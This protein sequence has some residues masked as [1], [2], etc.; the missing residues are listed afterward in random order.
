[1]AT[2]PF[3]V[4][5]GTVSLKVGRAGEKIPSFVAPPLFGKPTLRNHE[6]EACDFS[7]G[8]DSNW[9]DYAIFPLNPKEKHDNTLPVA[10]VTYENGKY[11]IS[12]DVM[13]KL[14]EFATSSK[15]VDDIMEGGTVIATEPTVHTP[16]F[17]HTMAE[18]LVESQ[19][20][21]KFYLC[22]RASLCC[23]ASGRGSSMVVDV[24]GACSNVA[25]VSEGFVLQEA[26]NE[27]PMGGTLLDRIFLAYLNQNSTTIRPS[28]E[29]VKAPKAEEN[30]G[31]KSQKTNNEMRSV[32]LRKLPYVRKEYYEYAR[33]YATSR[34]KETCCVIGEKLNV[35]A[36]PSNSCF[37]LPDGS[38][39]DVD[40]G[41]D[42]CG[43]FCRCLFN[44][45]EY[46]Q[47]AKK[48]KALESQEFPMGVGDGGT[49]LGQYFGRYC[50]LDG[51]L[52]KSYETASQMDSTACIP[53]ALSTVILSGGT[54]RHSAVL[55][56]LQKRFNDRMPG[57][58]EPSYMAVGGE[59]QQY[60]S[61]IGASILS[62][63]GIFESLC[64]SR[65][66]CQEHGLERILQRK[67]P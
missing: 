2:K 27:E 63:L 37:A 15:G 23:Y 42:L 67:C 39:L 26:T 57:V 19:R 53:D 49:S 41:K 43:I 51:L 65:E 56:L 61:F 47:D 34:V 28:F 1:M 25:V 54:T 58:E 11:K 9:L 10:A 60:S 18:I 46:L 32:G 17:R 38:Y 62:S 35:E 36:Q 22:K 13:D 24:G 64:I 52:A 55:P 31:N 8:N 45:P 40:M 30:G 50:G 59:E 44:E 20:V 3:I 21:D 4:D 48:F 14:L 16:E 7:G 29:Y 12:H 5:F 66:D 6:T 33:L